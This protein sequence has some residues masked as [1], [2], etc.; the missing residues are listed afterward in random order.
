MPADSDLLSG[1]LVRAVELLAETFAAKSIRY[2]LIGGLAT[3]MRGRPRFTQDVDIL[4]D[5]PQIV[6]P[7][8]LEEL[9]RVGFDLDLVTVIREYVREHVT[10]FR[11]GS[12]RIDWI[13]PVLPLYERTL[14]DASIL[15]WTEGHP[16][17][18]AT[19]EGL[20]LT[21]MVAF[22]PQDKSDIETLLVANWE[23]IDLAVIRQVWSVVATGEQARTAWLEEAIS[24]LVSQ[25]K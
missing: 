11:F 14:T 18:V 16:L 20:I 15:T 2:A 3:L 22:R 12:V 10:S 23:E 13:K 21:K 8:L 17:K 7:S 1:D 24:R 6:L 9:T 5:V 19:A 4:L 25:R